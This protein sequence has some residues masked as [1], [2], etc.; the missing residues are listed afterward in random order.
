MAAITQ[1]RTVVGRPET[2]DYDIIKEVA[3]AFHD[4]FYE[5]SI[6]GASNAKPSQVE[7]LCMLEAR[8]KGRQPTVVKDAAYTL[9]Q[10]TKGAAAKLKSS[11]ESILAR[12][13]DRRY[14]RWAGFLSAATCFQPWKTKQL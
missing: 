6:S 4:S 2:D 3:W 12:L 13:S 9:E 1:S 10:A 11:L 7:K 5:L 8:L 14:N